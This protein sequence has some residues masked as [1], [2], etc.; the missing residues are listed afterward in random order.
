MKDFDWDIAALLT[1][2]VVALVGFGFYV[3]AAIQTL[4]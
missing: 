4:S 1:V 2:C 3:Y